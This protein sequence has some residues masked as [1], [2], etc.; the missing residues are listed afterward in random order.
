MQKRKEPKKVVAAAVE[1]EIDPSE[2]TYLGLDFGTS[3]SA[4]A[5]SSGLKLNIASAVG[6]PKDFIAYNAVKKQIV[7][8]NECIQ[9]RTSLDIVYPLQKGVIKFRKTNSGKKSRND[10][11]AHAGVELLKYLL[12]LV[13]KKDNERVFAVVS[14]PANA[15]I[16]GKQAIINAAQGLVDSIMVVSEP[17]LVAYSLGIFGF[18]VIVDLGAGTLDICR[19]SGTIPDKTDQ[20]TLYIAGNE[21]DKEFYRLMKEKVSGIHITLNLARKIKE[22]YAFVGEG[23]D[24]IDVDFY[25]DGKLTT[26]DISNELREACSIVIPEICDNVR[27]LVVSFDP[28]LMSALVRN[29][30]LAG[31]GSRIRGLDKEIEANLSDLGSAQVTVVDDPFFQGA[32]GGLKFAQEIPFEEW[33]QLYHRDN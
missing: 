1:T 12:G 6:W 17:F 30:L 11:E 22:E 24:K 20:K 23:A 4:I 7:F 14:A 19:M 9:N 5:T 27:D 15:E 21:I 28:E 33:K 3:Q 25:V 26:I 18:A 32:L 29:I 13:E 10:R 31:G 2:I 16:A 8:G